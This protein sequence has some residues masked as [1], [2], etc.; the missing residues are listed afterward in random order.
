MSANLQTH[1]VEWRDLPYRWVSRQNPRNPAEWVSIVPAP[2]VTAD[3]R[4]S[5]GANVARA[6]H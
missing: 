3:A 2:I 5:L 6:T 1:I 4:S